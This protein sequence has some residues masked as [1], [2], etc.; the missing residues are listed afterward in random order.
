GV[1]KRMTGNSASARERRA[2]AERICGELD[3][4][5]RI[6][7]QVFYPAVRALH[8]EKLG[9][10]VHEST[11]EHATI[12][13]RVAAARAALDDD[14]ELRTRS[15]SLQECADPHGREEEKEMSPRLE[16]RMP[17][18]ERARLGRELAARKRMAAPRARKTTRRAATRPAQPVRTRKTTA[19]A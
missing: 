19:K 7:E 18:D 15:D 6:E 1:V 12:K 13:E 4:H 10:L 11:D 16:E 14:Q 9:E 2:T 3:V 8:D 17:E 5:A